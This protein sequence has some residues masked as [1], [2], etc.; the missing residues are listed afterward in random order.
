MKEGFLRRVVST[1]K[2]AVC[3]EQYQADNVSVVGHH[4][5]LWFLRVFCAGCRSQG[6]VAAVIKEGEYEE[7]HG[8]EV[9]EA[10][11]FVERGPVGADDV[12]D[13]HEFLRAFD[14]DFKSLFAST[15]E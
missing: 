10:F 2:C 5:E 7:E 14:G 6:L 4:E 1:M 3:G 8:P 13:M 9:E 15:P 12:L 11:A